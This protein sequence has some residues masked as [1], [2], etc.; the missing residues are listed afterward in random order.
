M[1]LRESPY[2]GSLT[3]P[4]VLEIASS[5]LGPDRSGDRKGFLE[6]VK[7]AEQIQGPPAPIA[8]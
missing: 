2:K 1:L 3:F 8:R 6:M 7:Q 5:S 4:A